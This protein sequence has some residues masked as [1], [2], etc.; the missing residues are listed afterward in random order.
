[1]C[2]VRSPFS[3]STA[4]LSIDMRSVSTTCSARA[5]PAAS[6]TK[7]PPSM[8]IQ[9]R[10]TRRRVNARARNSSITRIL[11]SRICRR[12]TGW[13]CSAAT[14]AA[15]SFAAWRT[16]E[17]GNS[18]WSVPSAIMKCPASAYT[19]RPSGAAS[20]HPRLDISSGL[21][22][23]SRSPARASSSCAADIDQSAGRR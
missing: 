3:G 6:T 8:S 22:G 21:Q 15:R 18:F 16:I 23:R 5:A 14:S 13:P 1:V 7:R 20:T 19:S 9:A 11:S 10:V 4:K 17:A 2:G 12:P